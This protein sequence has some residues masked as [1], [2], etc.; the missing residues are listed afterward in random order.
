MVSSNSSKKDSWN[1][2][3]IIVSSSVKIVAIL[4]QLTQKKTYI[5]AKTAR[6]STSLVKLEFL[7]H[8][9]S[10]FKRFKL[11]ALEQSSLHNYLISLT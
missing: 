6:I 4:L 9:N 11:W 10:F 1:V 2:Q 7:M 5:H 8:A 3:I